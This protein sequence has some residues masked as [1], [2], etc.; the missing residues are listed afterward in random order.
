MLRDNLQEIYH[1]VK[2][3]ENLNLCLTANFSGTR[4]YDSTR[5]WGRLW[6]WFYGIIDRLT[7][8]DYHLEKLKQAVIQTHLI[9]QKH[10]TPLQQNISCYENYLKKVGAGYEIAEGSVHAAR[11]GI[12]LWN[13]ST[14]PFVKLMRHCDHPKLNQLFRM[15]F[16]EDIDVLKLWCPQFVTTSE[17]LE[18]VID[19][20]GLSQGPLPLEVFKK[21][22]RKK[23]LNTLD[24]KAL[25]KWIKRINQASDCVDRLHSALKMIGECYHSGKNNDVNREV[26]RLEVFLEDKGCD[27][28]KQCDKQ[29]MHWR[30]DLKSGM[31][32]TYENQ[33]LVLGSQ[34]PS[35]KVDGDKTLVFTVDDVAKVVLVAQ[36]TSLLSMR[37]FRQIEVDNSDIEPAGLE[38]CDEGRWA[39]MERLQALDSRRWYSLPEQLNLHP[40]DCP[41]VHELSALIGKCV[42]QQI[43]PTNFSAASLMYDQQY[44]LK[45]LK[46]LI[47]KS[48][49]F[50]ALEDFAF[51]CAANNAV[52]FKHVMSASGLSTHPVGLFYH[53]IIKN[54]LKGDQTAIDD[55]AGIYKIVDPKIV[56]R[57]TSLVNE[58]L[59]LRDQH[60]LKMRQ[61]YPHKNIKS[62]LRQVNAK[63]ITSHKESGA[64]GRWLL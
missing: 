35:A 43:T 31:T 32:L 39:V 47:R 8:H 23:T 60:I 55:M 1:A 28:F 59:V 24:H 53:E 15:C 12:R 11:Q 27:V 64:C 5:G 57:G 3:S 18:K 14:L 30:K 33:Q 38:I 17:A 45:A 63:L 54:A 58:V 2:S 40:I 51:A 22:Q 52:V 41:L 44:R 62:I 25:D 7:F 6:R 61:T 9:F 26:T 56:E 10:L 20:E 34:I 21:I 36:N 37:Q 4:I 16:G 48:F 19:I 42:K 13:Q 50:N 49:D 46:P 29:Q